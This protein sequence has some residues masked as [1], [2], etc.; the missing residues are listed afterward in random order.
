MLFIIVIITLGASPPKAATPKEP[1]FPRLKGIIASGPAS[2]IRP[3]PFA[4]LNK[5]GSVTILFV[6]TPPKA[7]GITSPFS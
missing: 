2:P 3:V 6:K 5:V 7:K 1:S 4:N